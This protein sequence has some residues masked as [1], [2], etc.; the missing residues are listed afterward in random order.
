LKNAVPDNP[1]S[2]ATQIVM[3]SA[4]EQQARRV[5]GI[6]FFSTSNLAMSAEGFRQLGGF[7]ETFRRPA[8]EDYDFSARWQFRGGPA[9]YVPEAVVHHAHVLT[10]A[11]F[12]RQHAN[13]GRGLFRVR[14]LIASR[15]GAAMRVSP[16]SFYFS[17]VPRAFRYGKGVRRFVYTGLVVLSQLATLSGASYE[18]ILVGGAAPSDPAPLPAPPGKTPT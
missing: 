7:S 4:Y 9:E 3:D 16:A 1:C 15:T 18:A 6:R 5:G 10:L 11:G 13:Y 14:Q 17:L 2:T 8:G 12:A